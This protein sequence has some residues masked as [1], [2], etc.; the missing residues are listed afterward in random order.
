MSLLKSIKQVI[1]KNSPGAVVS[2][3]STAIGK[4]GAVITEGDEALSES[5]AEPQV[6]SVA[7]TRASRPS[8]PGKLEA[9]LDR[10][11]K[12]VHASLA[13]E[14]GDDVSYVT[15]EAV[16]RFDYLLGLPVVVTEKPWKAE[17]KPGKRGPITIRATVIRTGGDPDKAIVG[18]V[19][20]E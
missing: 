20:V 9:M 18:V 15:F 5:A 11:G 4:S 14:M 8:A 16:D 13:G 1:V 2:D 3:T 6:K 12:T 19:Q 10:D 17:I 7:T